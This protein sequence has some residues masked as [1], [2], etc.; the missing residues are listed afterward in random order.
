MTSRDVKPGLLVPVA[1]VIASW[2]IPPALL[3]V[4]RKSK[5]GRALTHPLMAAAVSAAA[6]RG[7]ARPDQA[8]SRQIG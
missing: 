5:L 6:R 8:Q 2:V 1:I 3:G 7:T 4:A